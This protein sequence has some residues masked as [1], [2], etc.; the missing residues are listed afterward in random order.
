MGGTVSL[1]YRWEG[2]APR[3]NHFL[4]QIS[5]ICP[6]KSTLCSFPP[7]FCPGRWPGWTSFQLGFT[8]GRNWQNRGG[9]K[10]KFYPLLACCITLTLFS[11]KCYR[12]SASSPVYTAFSFLV[13]GTNSSLFAFRFRCSNSYCA[14][15]TGALHEP[16]PFPYPLLTVWKFVPLWNPLEITL[17]NHRTHLKGGRSRDPTDPF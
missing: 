12:A 8:S 16:S 7:A 11:A 1:L 15:E 5:S 14:P 9:N 2:L 17:G 13:P 3:L 4:F 10:V 6:S